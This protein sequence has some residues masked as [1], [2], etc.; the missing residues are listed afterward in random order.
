MVLAV[1][2]S[3]WSLLEVDLPLRSSWAV[4]WLAAVS[5]NA[6]PYSRLG[7]S[8]VR[9]QWR[10]YPENYNTNAIWA[11]Q[12]TTLTPTGHWQHH[13]KW[14]GRPTRKA[15][16]HRIQTF[17]EVCCDCN[18]TRMSDG[19]SQWTLSTYAPSLLIRSYGYWPL[20]RMT[21]QLPASFS[22]A[23]WWTI[24]LGS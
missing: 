15:L 13:S 6:E 10:Q 1:L 18:W 7:R 14:P 17:D 16:I 24:W 21:I 22:E 5:V 11:Q 4:E 3:S 9:G 23:L 2:S 12:P 20:S 19:S 8:N